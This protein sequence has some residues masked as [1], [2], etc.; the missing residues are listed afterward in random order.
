MT[1]YFCRTQIRRYAPWNH[2]IH[3]EGVPTREKS[4]AYRRAVEDD[5]ACQT[6]TLGR[7]SISEN[8]KVQPHSYRSGMS[9]LGCMNGAAFVK[10]VFTRPK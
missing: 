2:T 4:T 1:Q 6:S 10:N 9:D 3:L 5:R 8:L 7:A